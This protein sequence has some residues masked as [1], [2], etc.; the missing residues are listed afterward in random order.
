[1]TGIDWPG[2]FE[3]TPADDREPNRNFEATLGQTTDDLA[4]EMDRLD[5]DEWR[6]STGNSHTKSNT[7][8]LH[9]A[10]PDDPGF[11]LRWTK[12]G[13]QFAVACDEYSRLRD[14]VRE[15][16]LWVHETRMRGNRSVVTGESEFAAARLPSGD[17]EAVAASPPP[18]DVLDVAP[19]APDGV[20]NAAYREKT[21]EMHPDH[22][23][24]PEAFQ[25]LKRAKEAMLNG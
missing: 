25:R 19:D 9:N 14:N 6:A 5:P 21:K 4:T 24:S 2:G 8:P 1:M 17:G 12:D 13:E 3:R 10:N 11:V 15:V 20:V 18:H 7:L 16:Y 23:G 22:G